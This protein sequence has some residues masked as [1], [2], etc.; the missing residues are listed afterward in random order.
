MSD[1]APILQPDLSH[2]KSIDPNVV[3]VSLI[4]TKQTGISFAKAKGSLTAIS[5]DCDWEKCLEEAVSKKWLDCDQKK[6]RLSNAGMQYLSETFPEDVAT[7]TWKKLTEVYLPLL[8]MGLKGRQMKHSSGRGTADLHAAV[9]TLLYN[10]PISLQSATPALACSAILWRVIAKRFPE[11]DGKTSGQPAP[12]KDPYSRKLFCLA[13][14]E[15]CNDVATAS[16]MLACRPLGITGK[17]GIEELRK[18]L[19]IRGLSGQRIETTPS[20]PNQPSKLDD[21]KAFA[22][23]VQEIAD[24]LSIPPFNEKVS[25]SQVYDAYGRKYADAG[26]IV[27]FKSRLLQS[28][29]SE[30]IS[31]KRSDS[32]KML[33]PDIRS[34]SEIVDGRT[35]FHFVVKS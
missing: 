20:K 23:R 14:G 27:E 16:K 34:R 28:L 8:S 15:N 7:L 35:T 32:P 9:L 4:A 10:L 30:L 3:L 19:L 22:A 29:R 31:L 11:F 21:L 6:L 26:K 13:T 12:I 33:S 5:K 2:F 25:I 17:C 24:S 1:S 18:V